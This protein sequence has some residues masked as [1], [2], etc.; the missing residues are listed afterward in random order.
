MIVR[1][2][3]LGKLVG[4]VG[5]ALRLDAH[6]A[7][8]LAL[9]ALA[10]WGFS[11]LA[12]DVWGGDPPLRWDEAM[13]AWVHRH[14]TTR[15]ARIFGGI[16]QLGNATFTLMMAAAIAPALRRHRALLVGWIAA[17]LGSFAIQRGLKA[18]VQRVRPP[19][20]SAFLDVHSFSFPSGHATASMVAYVM[21]AYA[22][23][24]LMEASLRRRLVLYLG[25]AVIIG[26]VGFSRIYLGVHYPSDIL[27][28]YAV[29][30]AWVAICLTGVGIAERLRQ[31]GHRA[32]GPGL[33]A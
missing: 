18:V 7:A 15:G 20:A 10:I 14:T 25:A 9:A 32:E 19:T 26:A 2:A 1:G 8:T 21:L 28:G 27:A 6:L 5:H 24:R 30:L 13:V 29:G 17:F 31:T 12:A 23:S 11:I 4:R 3:R 22:L 16:T 33:R